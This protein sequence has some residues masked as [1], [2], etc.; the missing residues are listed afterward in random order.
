MGK[1]ET[2]CYQRNNVCTTRE[3]CFGSFLATWIEYPATGMATFL[4]LIM[5][6]LVKFWVGCDG[7]NVYLKGNPTDNKAVWKYY[8]GRN[9]SQMDEDPEAFPLVFERLF[10]QRG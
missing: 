10:C 3:L 9:F 6:Q 5:H 4:L 7:V 1:G 2:H 8:L